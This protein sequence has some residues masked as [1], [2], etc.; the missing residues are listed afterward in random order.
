[1]TAAAAATAAASRAPVGMHGNLAYARLQ[2]YGR[3]PWEYRAGRLAVSV[4]RLYPGAVNDD[5]VPD[6]QIPSPDRTVSRVRCELAYDV[7][8]WVW[9]ARCLSRRNAL[10]VD[11]VPVPAD[12]VPLPLRSRHL[13]E[14]G[15]AVVVFLDPR[16]AGIV[17]RRPGRVR[18][19]AAEAGGRR[20][21][22][23]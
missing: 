6:W 21:R 5:D 18:V 2:G 22:R 19:G 16:G 9:V 23:R 7:P 13:V 20:G 14:L 1:M 8:Q 10:A 4:G 12:A 3:S 17:Y 11:G 15:D